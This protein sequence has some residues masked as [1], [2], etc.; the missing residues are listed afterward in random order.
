MRRLLLL[1][2]ALAATLAAASAPALAASPPSV[3][4]RSAI[5]VDASSGDV[6]YAKDADARRPIASTTKLMT[7]LLTLQDGGL[8]QSVTADRYQGSAAESRLPLLPGE[9]MTEAD[10]LRALL[11]RSANDAAVT[12]ATHEAGSVPSFVR[13]MN[14]R[15]QQLGLKNTHYENP[16][17]LDDAGNYSS[18]RDLAKLTL[19]LRHNRFFRRT[20]NAQKLT[21]RSGDHVRTIANRNTLLDGYPWVDGVKTGHTSQAGYCMVASGSKR[22]VRLV[23][24]VLGTGSETERNASSVQLLNYGFSRYVQRGAISRGDVVVRVPIDHRAGAT[25]PLVAGRTV[26][27]VVRRGERFRFRREVPSSVSGPISYGQAIGKLVILVRGKP[28]TSVTLR[29]MLEVP[30]AGTGRQVQDALLGPWTLVVLGALLLASVA[31]AA[32]R[33]PRGREERF[34]EAPSA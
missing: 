23:S 27:R 4:A 14:R 21:L 19:K 25:L 32:R 9:H 28:V 2:A 7:A 22:G 17:G 24:V 29:S 18:A 3:P 31:L 13:R 30:R 11:L 10:L 8:S 1:L 6:A 5:V 33:T 20:V 26:R 16:I 34:G 15:A 12:L